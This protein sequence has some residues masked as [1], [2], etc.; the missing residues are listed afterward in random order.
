MYNESEE[1]F[2]WFNR[3]KSREKIIM[4]VYYSFHVHR[5]YNLYV[6]KIVGGTFCAK[7]RYN[8]NLLIDSA[9]WWKFIFKNWLNK[10][11]INSFVIRLLPFLFVSIKPK[12]FIYFLASSYI[13]WTNGKLL[14]CYECNNVHFHKIKN[15]PSSGGR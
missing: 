5:I 10:S 14:L 6:K 9:A 4:P 1:F 8:L 13:S 2:L 7:T 3:D 15:W 11:I 12:V